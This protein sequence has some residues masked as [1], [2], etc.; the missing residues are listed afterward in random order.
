[1]NT[2]CVMILASTETIANSVNE[3]I[4]MLISIK[5]YTV[6]LCLITMICSLI[7]AEPAPF[8]IYLNMIPERIVFV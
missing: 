8:V 5:D 4:K 6:L 7:K 1:M 3:T 2:S